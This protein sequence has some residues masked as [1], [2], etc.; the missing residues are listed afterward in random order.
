MLTVAVAIC[1][2][3]VDVRECNR[4][5]GRACP[6]SGPGAQCN[7]RGCPNDG[8]AAKLVESAGCFR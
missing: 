2:S 5:S 8:A 1:L 4:I 6:D 3:S 7:S